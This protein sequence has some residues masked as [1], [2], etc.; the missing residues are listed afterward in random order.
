LGI[1]PQRVELGCDRLHGWEF[2]VGVAFLADQLPTH[3]RSIQPRVQS[4]G[5]KLGINLALRINNG[6]NIGEELGQMRFS[7]LAPARGEVV[8]ADP[9]TFQFTGAF[10]NRLTIP[11]QGAFGTPLAARPEFFDGF[12]P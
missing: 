3:L 1:V 11:A 2:S 4:V 9:A 6:R 12:A 8:Q 10:T 5:A 7:W